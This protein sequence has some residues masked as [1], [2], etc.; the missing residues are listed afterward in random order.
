MNLAIQEHVRVVLQDDNELMSAALDKYSD[1]DEGNKRLNRELIKKHEHILAKFD[2]NEQLSQ[3]DF[4]L[5]RD[6]NQIHLNDAEELY[7]HHNQAL[8]LDTWLDN[9]I[10]LSKGEAMRILE[11]YLDKDPRTPAKVYRALHTMWEEATPN[12]TSP[13]FDR[14]GRC[15]KCSSKVSFADVTDRLVFVGDEI[16]KRYDGDITNRNCVRCAHPKQYPDYEDYDV[17]DDG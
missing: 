3:E 4:Q 1:L 2:K 6:A 5:I 12:D 8:E 7:G 11:E 10:E 9:M 16:V 13:A 15:L 14:E 17:G